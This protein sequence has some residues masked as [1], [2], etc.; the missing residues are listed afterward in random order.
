M[1]CKVFQ[2]THQILSEVI[3]PSSAP[4]PPDEPRDQPGNSDEEVDGEVERLPITEA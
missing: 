4:L 3:P 1:A 2:L